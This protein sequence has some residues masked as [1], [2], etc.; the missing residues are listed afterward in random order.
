M[1]HLAWVAE[2][3]EPDR[4][5][6]VR[7]LLYRLNLNPNE[8]DELIAGIV[9]NPPDAANAARVIA[10]RAG[11]PHDRVAYTVSRNCASGLE[12]V[13]EALDRVLSGRATSVIELGCE[14]MSNIPVLFTQQFGKKLFGVIRA[15][16]LLKQLGAIARFRVRDLK[17]QIGIQMGLTDPVSELTMGATAEKLSREYGVSREQL[18]KSWNGPESP[19]E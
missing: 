3:R 12:A 5:V 10:L 7:E 4:A 11:I 9:A 2:R 14:S 16:G 1:R 15:R 18:P 6:V 13:T 19:R 17:P 8:I